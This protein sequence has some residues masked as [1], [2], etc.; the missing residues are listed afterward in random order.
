MVSCYFLFVQVTSLSSEITEEHLLNAICRIFQIS[1]GC[2]N[3]DGVPMPDVEEIIKA[4]QGIHSYFQ[5]L[6]PF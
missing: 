1:V 3:P 6:R 4:D 2:C 5:D